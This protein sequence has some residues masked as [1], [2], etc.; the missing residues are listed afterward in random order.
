[1]RHSTVAIS[2]SLEAPHIRHP[3]APTPS[4]GIAEASVQARFEV[5]APARRVLT[6]HQGTIVVVGMLAV[7]GLAYILRSPSVITGPALWAEDG[8][9]FFKD[10]VER[11]WASMFTPYGGQLIVFPRTVAA[12][13][14]PLPAAMQPGLYAAAAMAAAV[15]SCG[16]VL[17]SRWR[18]AAPIPVRFACL[19]AL[20]CAPGVLEAYGT[21]ANAHWWLGVGLVLLA[22]L[23]DPSVRHTRVGEVVFA[24]VAG[25][26]GF[27]AIFAIPAL[28]VRALRNRSRHSWTVAGVAVLGVAVQMT[29][30]LGS[31]RR[32]NFAEIASDPVA[33]VLVLAKRVL[34]TAALGE[35]NLADLWPLRSPTPTAIIVVVVLVT[36]MGMIWMRGARLEIGALLLALLGSWFLALWAL[37]Q[38]GGSLDMLF[39]PTA[40]GRYFLVPIAILYISLLVARPIGRA[41]TPL[42]AVAC[43][44]L[45]TGIVSDYRLPLWR[46]AVDPEAAHWESFARC[47]DLG[48]SRCSTTIPPGWSLEVSR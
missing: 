4:E 30:L 19:L 24:A 29:Y 45:L 26:S 48:G 23:R 12:L 28:V 15:L 38:P 40:A 33:A 25:T 31:A 18:D 9:V 42:V 14:A 43:V 13:V 21:L 7:A 8:T 2:G 34:A 35:T 41:W 20:V 22:M 46:V 39:W 17:S 6:A 32:G 27:A 36:A 11:G 16:I 1:M 5:V 44:L 47:V 37:T 10:A 3:I